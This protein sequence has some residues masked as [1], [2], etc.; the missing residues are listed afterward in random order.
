MIIILL[1]CWSNTLIYAWLVHSSIF[2]VHH[3]HTHTRN[4]Q[5]TPSSSLPQQRSHFI[6]TL[7]SHHPHTQSPQHPR[8]QVTATYK[9]AKSARQY[10]PDHGGAAI[11]LST[12]EK[13]ENKQY[14]QALSA[15]SSGELST[16][17]VGVYGG[18]RGCMGVDSVGY[19][20]DGVM[21]GKPVRYWW[22]RKVVVL[23]APRSPFPSPPCS[24]SSTS[25]PTSSPTS[26]SSS[27]SFSVVALHAQCPCSD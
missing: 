18:M 4:F 14:T 23:L 19:G 6:L 9:D 12:V 15:L 26:F 3:P 16:V 8:V 27:S 11:L 22:Y 20:F 25:S 5:P 17:C 1:C 7:V 2:L 13:A 21:C 24:S 10:N